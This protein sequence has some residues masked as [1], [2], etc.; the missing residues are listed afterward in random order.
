[1]Y[2]VNPFVDKNDKVTMINSDP[3]G[4]IPQMLA[5]I[6][7]DALVNDDYGNVHVF[8]AIDTAVAASDIAI[9][10]HIM[11]KLL[12]DPNTR[13][14]AIIVIPMI[15]CEAGYYLAHKW[16]AELVLYSTIQTKMS[17][18]SHAMGQPHNPATNT[19]GLLSYRAE[20]MTLLQRV[21]NTILTFAFDQVVR[22]SLILYKVNQ[23]L[24]KNFPG[25]ERP[26]LLALEKE[27]SLAIAFGHP[28]ILDG[29]S[30][31]VPNYVQVGMMNCRP[32][33]GFASGDNIGEFM[34]KSKNGV[35]FV[36]FGTVLK[37]SLMS[38]PRRKL[39]LKVFSRFPQYDFIWKWETET[40]EG[41]PANI[42][43]SKW[44]P[45]QDILAH[46]KLKVFITHAGQSSFQ[47]T[48]CHQ[49]PVVAIPIYEDQPAN[50]FETE[51]LG[52]GIAQ[53]YQ[54][55]NEEDLFNALDKVLHDPQYT[56]NAKKVGALLNDQINRPLDRA[57]WWIEHIIRHPGMYKGKSPVHKLYWFQYFLLDVFAVL[58]VALYLVLWII[59]FICS[60]L[61]C[62]K[63]KYQKGSK[64][65]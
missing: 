7:R 12:A 21:Q 59:R 19:F 52:F 38:E 55:L 42:M 9:N 63:A 46:P 15:A 31:N 51:R 49:K 28:F 36:S 61:F 45:Q 50:A 39:I 35:I 24:D 10:H 29:W 64:L 43:L 6:S 30:A 22:N 40:M 17:F 20:S 18:M 53:P 13:F 47:E 48:L 26:S 25:E 34:N 32:A 65:D 57:V 5:N 14:D 27:A 33:K 56:E 2:V 8:H 37:G 54:T 1:V 11:K 58:F 23:M 16:K 62:K 44:L 60:C 4:I 41:K 3:E